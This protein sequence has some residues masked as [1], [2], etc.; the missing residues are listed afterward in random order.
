MKKHFPGVVSVVLSLLLSLEPAWAQEP[1]EVDEIL[2]TNG[3]RI[4]GS[5]TGARDGV[6]NVDT[7]FAGELEIPVDKIASLRTVE[8][9]VIQMADERVIEGR[10]LEIDDQQVVVSDAEGGQQSLALDELLRVNPEP[11]ELGQGYKWTGLVTFA[12]NVERGNTEID[13]LDYRL[14]TRW[15]SDDDRYTLQMDA[16]RDEA[17][18]QKNADNWVIRGKYD[19][20][21][22]DATYWG[23]NAFAESDEFADLDLRYLVGPYIGH[24]FFTSPLFMLSAELG[25]SYVNE[26]FIVAEDKDYPAANWTLNMSSDYLGGDSRLYF[27]QNGIWN[28]D[29]AA[30]VII[31]NTFGLAF[32]LLWDLEAAAEVFLKYDSGAPAGIEKLEEKY[33][34]RIGYTW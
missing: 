15:R 9:V 2:L 6:V 18:G 21:V 33:S 32:P 10:Q 28:L 29:K 3:S 12:L 19:Y 26:N 8:P 1:A 20:F 5:I 30:D 31:S 7:E 22:S 25:A 34:F 4:L 27:N 24:E 11:W 23:A 16:S 17:G 13:E 14:D